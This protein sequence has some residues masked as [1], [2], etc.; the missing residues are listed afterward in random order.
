[1]SILKSIT[2]SL[3]LFSG[4]IM[5]SCEDD[6]IENSIDHYVK[7]EIESINIRIDQQKGEIRKTSGGNGSLVITAINRYNEGFVFSLNED[8]VRP[9]TYKVFPPKFFQD[10]LIV[11]VYSPNLSSSPEYLEGSVTITAV[12]QNPLLFKATFEGVLIEFNQQ[13]SLMDTF[14][15]KNGVADIQF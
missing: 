1:M 15:V 9:G 5:V 14:V 10:T 2:W 4:L 6:E 12:G 7:A 3:L 8:L 11:Y 13:T